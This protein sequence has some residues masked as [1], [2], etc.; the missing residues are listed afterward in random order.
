MGTNIQQNIPVVGFYCLLLGS[1]VL[2][3]WGDIMIFHWAKG[4]SWLQLAGGIGAWVVSLVLMAF[5]FRYSNLPFAV[6]IVL[7]VM[8]HVFVD[9]IWDVGVQRNHFS[10]WQWTGVFFAAIAVVLLQIEK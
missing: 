8:I 1:A 10:L 7:L 5:V 9:V 4:G 6:T 3:G 2:S